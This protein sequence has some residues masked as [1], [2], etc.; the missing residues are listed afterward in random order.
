M[1]TSRYHGLGRRG[2]VMMDVLAAFALLAGGVFLSV[3]FFRTE[4]RELR[5]TH[6]R[7]AA[8]LIAESEIERLHTLSYEEI[9]RGDGQPLNLTLP[10]ARRL[11][12]GRGTLSVKEIEPGL[13]NV[14][15]RI[16]WSSPRGRPCFVEMRSV[17]SKE[18]RLR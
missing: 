9:A 15:V 3:V 17:L 6:E 5:Y 14:T 12:E 11:K 8:L 18:G 2:F 4:V 7:L 1:V 13:K 16:Q 10:S